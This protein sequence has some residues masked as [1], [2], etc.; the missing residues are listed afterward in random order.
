MYFRFECWI[1]FGVEKKL[2][3]IFDVKNC[4]LSIYEVSTPIQARQTRFLNTYTFLITFSP[5][6]T[7]LV[8]SSAKDPTIE[9]FASTEH[10]IIQK[11][12]HDDH[13]PDRVRAH[14]NLC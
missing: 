4:D 3:Y 1:F 7:H 5:Q 14:A 8:I 2:G 10:K 13:P 11:N 9:E 6:P 12:L